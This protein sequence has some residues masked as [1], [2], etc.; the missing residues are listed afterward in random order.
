MRTG[1]WKCDHG[2]L[3]ALSPLTGPAGAITTNDMT[4]TFQV[5]DMS[6]VTLPAS[7]KP[8]DTW[9]Q[10]F[11][12]EGTAIRQRSD[13]CCQRARSPSTAPPV[14][15]EAVTVAAGSFNAQRVDCKINLTVAV[16][17][18]GL[19]IPTSFS[20]DTSMW[21]APGVGLVKLDGTIG[22]MG[23]GTIELTGYSI[24]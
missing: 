24:P 19:Q 10:D 18:G 3:I 21:Y 8:G 23:S 9:T 15:A 2:A 4:A 17:M 11:T 13:C 16:D 14:L 6:G 22:G 12:V 20:G 1:E 5:S 7:V